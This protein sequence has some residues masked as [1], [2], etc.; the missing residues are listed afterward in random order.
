MNTNDDDLFATTIPLAVCLPAA[1]RTR[2]RTTFEKSNDTKKSAKDEE[3]DDETAF[4]SASS[5]NETILCALEQ[6]SKISDKMCEDLEREMDGVLLKLLEMDERVQKCEKKVKNA[7]RIKEDSLLLVVES[8]REYPFG[9]VEKSGRKSGGG[10]SWCRYDDTVREALRKANEK[11]PKRR[12]FKDL[13]RMAQEARRYGDRA[14]AL[15]RSLMKGGDGGGRNEFVVD[16]KRILRRRGS[17]ADVV[18]AKTAFYDCEA[19]RFGGKGKGG[20]GDALE[21]KKEKEKEEEEVWKDGN[22]AE[23]LS[24]GFAKKLF[25]SSP[26]PK[27]IAIPEE[28]VRSARTRDADVNNANTSAAGDEESVSAK[29]SLESVFSF[30]PK[31]SDAPVVVFPG[32]LPSPGPSASKKDTGEK[33]KEGDGGTDLYE[34]TLTSENPYSPSAF[35]RN[36]P[37]RT[38]RNAQ[39]PKKKKG[40]GS[41]SALTSQKR[42]VGTSSNSS[43]DNVNRPAPASVP[44]PPPPP[45][46]SNTSRQKMPSLAAGDDGRGALMEAI[47]RGANLRKVSVSTDQDKKPR[48]S[49]ATSDTDDK[50]KTGA[51]ERTKKTAADASRGGAQ[52]S[53]ME[54][55]ASQLQRRR[56]TVV[57]SQKDSTSRNAAQ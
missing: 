15:A 37:T 36:P 13:E 33:S 18:P 46:P 55:L 22:E 30:R 20:E 31:A 2:T 29:K 51:G 56:S 10:M 24:D 27:S 25:L 53:M 42:S 8:S 28:F 48:K 17:L 6:V 1:Q 7:Q 49:N 47:R 35:L 12:A 41:A 5:A 11:R 52:M 32:T 14:R 45:P 57:S 16:A 26:P 40:G 9:V 4:S 50:T 39:P 34:F 44:A 3:N 23:E 19:L 43:N 54:E 38:T 21:E